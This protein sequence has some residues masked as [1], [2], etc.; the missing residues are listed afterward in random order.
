VNALNRRW[1]LGLASATLIALLAGVAIGSVFFPNRALTQPTLA[2]N[3]SAMLHEVIFNDTGNCPPPPLGYPA[4]WAVSLDNKT[5]VEPPGAGFPP[6]AYP[7]ISP[8]FKN[9]SVI[10]FSVPDGTYQYTVY[11]QTEFYLDNGTVVVN[12]SDVVVSAVINLEMGGG[13]LRH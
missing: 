2:T 5:I 8:A 12:G 6:P 3:T 13:C 1:L 9:Y 4:S 10:T 11:P 7:E